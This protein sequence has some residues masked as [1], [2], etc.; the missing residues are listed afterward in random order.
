MLNTQTFRDEL[1]LN[2][3]DIQNGF[4]F[5]DELH[6][7]EA[8]TPLFAS[9][10]APSISIG[11]E[12][13]YETLKLPIHQF[14]IKIK[15]S[16]YYQF[17]VP[18]KGD[19][20]ARIA[21]NM[22]TEGARFATLSERFWGYMNNE[23]V[24]QFEKMDNYRK[25]GF[26]LSQSRDILTELFDFYNLCWERHFECVMPRGSLGL[27]LEDAYTKLTGDTNATIVYDFVEGVMNKSLETDREIWKLAQVVKGDEALANIFA[28]TAPKALK[29]AL[30]QTAAGQAFLAQV[31]QVM[32]I[33]GW[34]IAISHEFANETWYENPAYALEIIAKYVQKDNDFEAEFAKVVATRE[35]KVADLLAKYPDGEAKDHF[36][37]I[38]S[39][40]L[41]YWGVDEDHHFYIDAMLPA[42]SRLLLLDMGQLLVDAKAIEAKEDIFF[43]YLD[44]LVDLVDAPQDVTAKIA[45]RKAQHEID[46]NKK[47]P[48]NYGTPP[49]EPVAPIIERIFGTKMAEVDEVAQSFKGYAASKGVHKGI[50]RIV[51]DQDD[52]EKVTKGDVLVCKTTL[53]PWTVLFSIAGAVITDA[54]GILS[55]AGTVAREYQLPAV[56]GTKVATSM[57][58]DEDVVTVD[59]TAGIVTIEK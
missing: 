57:L 9:Y 51:R 36:K 8:L 31:Q 16:H 12:R 14:R 37:L 2:D 43:L 56:L 13:A 6:L 39:W 22:A 4:W 35:Q 23:L 40:A 27:A 17:N 15:D 49:Q 58:K 21:E 18:Y 26:T 34:R 10:M 48:A 41:A 50:V 5:L 25:N 19:M 42:K 54:G 46:S 7:P 47:I 20:N 32:D 11:T 30:A 1:L 59:G 45:Q 53:P 33:Y 44:E 52:F 3:E 55:H 24:P 38:H 28:T 29:E